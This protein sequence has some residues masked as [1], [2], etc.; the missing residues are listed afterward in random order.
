MDNERSST[1]GDH[2]DSQ[3]ARRFVCTRY[4]LCRLLTVYINTADGGFINRRYHIE[5]AIVQLVYGPVR[6]S[7][8]LGTDGWAFCTAGEGCVGSGGWGKRVLLVSFRCLDSF[9]LIL[10]SIRII[11]YLSLIHI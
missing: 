7:I 10:V 8:V 3:P 6:C 2:E 1:G 11:V 5:Y 9:M 4:L